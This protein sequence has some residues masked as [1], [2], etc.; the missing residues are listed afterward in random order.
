MSI[1]L[2]TT[3]DLIAD[4]RSLLDEENEAA[5]DDVRDVLPALNRAQD[6][7]AN[8]LAR[9]YEEPLLTYVSLVTTSGVAEYD[10]PEDVFEDRLQKIEVARPSGTYEEVRRISYKDVTLY[11]GT[12]TSAKPIYYCVVGRKFR[13]LPAPTGGVTLRLWILSDPPAL[14][15]PYGR[16]LSTSGTSILL[17]D[18]RNG[19]GTSIEDLSAFANVIDGKTG[20]V[21]GTVQMNSLSTDDDLVTCATV[22]TRTEVLG[23]TVSALSEIDVEADDF[24]CSVGGTCIPVLKKPTSNFLIAHAHAALTRKLGGEHEA[25]ARVQSEYED[26]LKTTFTNREQTRRVKRT[27]TA[28]RTRLP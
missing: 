6:F 11:E 18:L 3:E 8:V 23:R 26:Q 17:D 21:K 15:L 16:I 1:R 19:P 12:G 9:R 20:H 4:V 28:R 13:L 14:V 22:P 24:L 27:K 25:L 5:I 7:A 2:L 10:F